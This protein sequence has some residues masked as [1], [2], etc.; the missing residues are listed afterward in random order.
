MGPLQFLSFVATTLDDESVS[1]LTLLT[2]CAI[3]WVDAEYAEM[4]RALVEQLKEEKAATLMAAG[5]LTWTAPSHETAGQNKSAH[6][7][8]RSA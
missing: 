6:E 2:Q 4:E 7:P 1:N 8:G 5:L 3:K